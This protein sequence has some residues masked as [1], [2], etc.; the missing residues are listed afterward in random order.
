MVHADWRVLSLAIASEPVTP[1]SPGSANIVTGPI[2]AGEHADKNPP[3]KSLPPRARRVEQRTLATL[4]LRRWHDI[5]NQG[6][7]PA[8]FRCRAGLASHQPDVWPKGSYPA[9]IV[10]LGTLARR[11]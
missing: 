1:H 7:R 11:S 9:P 10:N 3:A 5:G 8:K 4:A 6:Q 2:A